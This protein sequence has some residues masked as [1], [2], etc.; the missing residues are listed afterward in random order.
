MSTVTPLAA[1][2]KGALSIKEGAAYCGI[3]MCYM[4]R[5]IAAGKGPKVVRLGRRKLLRPVDLD[6][7]LA[8]KVDGG[9]DETR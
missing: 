7:W 9:G 8:S 1:A 3:H 4:Y 6:A 2:V 5:L